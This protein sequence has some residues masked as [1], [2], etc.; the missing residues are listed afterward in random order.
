VGSREA[1]EWAPAEKQVEVATYV[2]D[3]AE[4]VTIDP[5]T[6][7]IKGAK[8]FLY[9]RIG[10]DGRV[11]HVIA[12]PSPFAEEDAYRE[13]AVTEIHARLLEASLQARRP[14]QQG[15]G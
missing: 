11:E 5:S 12:R 15:E 1:A 2:T 6:G 13:R 10:S 7:G 14:R 9:S 3:E 8:L 4:A